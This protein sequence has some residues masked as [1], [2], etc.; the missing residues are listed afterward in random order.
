MF[1]HVEC[2]DQYRAGVAHSR[3]QRRV[4]DG[5]RIACIHL[6]AGQRHQP[7]D[8]EQVLHGVGYAGK[9][10]QRLTPGAHFVDRRRLAACTLESSRSKTIQVGIASLDPGF[11]FSEYRSGAQGAFANPP[12]DVGGG[13]GHGRNTGAASDANGSGQLKIICATDSMRE[14]CRVIS[15]ICAASNS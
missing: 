3:D 8:I 5:R 2:A 11:R 9:R 10:R 13:A 4:G 14:N 7:C 1:I 6:A 12:H 15:A